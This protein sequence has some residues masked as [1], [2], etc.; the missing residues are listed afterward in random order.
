[1]A[2]NRWKIGICAKIIP[3]HYSDGIQLTSTIKSTSVTKCPIDWQK[4]KATTTFIVYDGIFL[5]IG[6]SLK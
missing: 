5:S 3:K 2:D 4:K 6:L 1:M